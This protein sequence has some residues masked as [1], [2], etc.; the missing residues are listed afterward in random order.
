MLQDDRHPLA[1]PDVMD[2][3]ARQIRVLVVPINVGHG[4]R[5]P[6]KVGEVLS[7]GATAK[8]QD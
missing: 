7:E 6:Q 3:Y 1:V 2:L 4:D 5:D 8:L